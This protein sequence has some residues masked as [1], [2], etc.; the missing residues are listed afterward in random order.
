R[1]DN[2]VNHMRLPD[3][4]H[5]CVV[6]ECTW[7]LHNLVQI[8]TQLRGQSSAIAHFLFDVNLQVSDAVASSHWSKQ[9]GHLMN[10]LGQSLYYHPGLATPHLNNYPNNLQTMSHA[11][12]W[13]S[14]ISPP[15]LNRWVRRY[16]PND[17]Y[18]NS[19]LA[20]SHNSEYKRQKDQWFFERSDHN[21]PVNVRL[22]PPQN[23]WI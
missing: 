3:V 6:S 7:R 12:H 18:R 20:V 1:L 22:H 19:S 4:A 9:A 16:K 11:Y 2:A 14:Q 8:N 13:W 23:G 17:L 21:D 15:D 5:Y 10:R